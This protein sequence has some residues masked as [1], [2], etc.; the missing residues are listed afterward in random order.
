MILV[1]S[2]LRGL[3]SIAFAE[4]LSHCGAGGLKP[5]LFLDR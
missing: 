2:D 4:G 5:G 3:S 1:H